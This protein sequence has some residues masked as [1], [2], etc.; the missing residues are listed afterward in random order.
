MVCGSMLICTCTV[1]PWSPRIKHLAT[2][3]ML[4]SHH[5][6]RLE[7]ALIL[8]VQPLEHTHNEPSNQGQREVSQISQKSRRHISAVQAKGPTGVLAAGG[9]EMG[10]RS[11]TERPRLLSVVIP[12]IHRIPMKNERWPSFPGDV[13]ID[14]NRWLALFGKRFAKR[15]SV[16]TIRWCSWQR[17]SDFVNWYQ[18][19]GDSTA[20]L[21][22]GFNVGNMT[23]DNQKKT[24]FPLPT[25]SSNPALN[26]EQHMLASPH[27]K[28]TTNETEQRKKEKKTP[29]HNSQQLITLPQKSNKIRR[30][31]TP[32]TPVASARTPPAGW[33][34]W[35]WWRSPRAPGRPRTS[36]SLSFFV[37]VFF[38]F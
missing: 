33:A 31:L 1:V 21:N 17:G 25:G 13:T 19:L 2:H 4:I 26:M 15:H 9:S 12:G 38:F 20:C 7:Y 8:K 35:G 22:H 23:I 18:G 10:S 16:Q 3:A 36:A 11:E 6:H 24:A 30:P 14:A 28:N 27:P 37:F 32:R 34:P 29:K 5:C